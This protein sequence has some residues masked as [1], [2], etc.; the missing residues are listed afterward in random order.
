MNEN[1]KFVFNEVQISASESKETSSVIDK[2]QMCKCLK[3]S[4]IQNVESS[5]DYVNEHEQMFLITWTTS[6][7]FIYQL[8]KVHKRTHVL[9]I[10]K[11]NACLE[12]KINEF[13]YCIL[14]LNFLHAFEIDID[15][16]HKLSC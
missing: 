6:I 8:N 16:D 1:A 10:E 9:G 2:A 4:C 14:M 11:L 13:G 15:E 3:M 7:I 12:W 5:K